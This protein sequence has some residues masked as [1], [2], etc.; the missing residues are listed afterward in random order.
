MSQYCIYFLIASIC[1][2]I[3]SNLNFLLYMHSNLEKHAKLHAT[4]IK[5]EDGK[6]EEEE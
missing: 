3:F 1:V 4:Q 2:C 5:E 6:K